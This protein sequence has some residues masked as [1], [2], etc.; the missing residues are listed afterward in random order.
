[1]AK[2]KKKRRAKYM[3]RHRKE[4]RELIRI[5]KHFL[6][7]RP[8]LVKKELG[9]IPKLTINPRPIRTSQIKIPQPKFPSLFGESKNKKVKKKRRRKK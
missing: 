2:Q 4:E 9:R 1:M 6:L 5:G 3:Q 7:K 8:E